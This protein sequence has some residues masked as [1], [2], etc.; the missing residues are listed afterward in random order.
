[1]ASVP[2]ILGVEFIKQMTLD[3]NA[4]QVY[5]G[6]NSIFRVFYF[7]GKILKSFFSIE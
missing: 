7:A 5:L 1:M 2:N 3:E 6:K 4:G